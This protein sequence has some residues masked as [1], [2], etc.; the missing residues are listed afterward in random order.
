M[1]LLLN[2]KKKKSQHYLYDIFL[3]YDYFAYFC[4][5]MMI[6]CLSFSNHI[7]PRYDL[8][9]GSVGQGRSKDNKPKPYGSV[10][11]GRSKDNIYIT[12][13]KLKVYGSAYIFPHN[14]TNK[15]NQKPTFQI[16]SSKFHKTTIYLSIYYIISNFRKNK[17]KH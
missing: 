5:T 6:F 17:I 16:V 8:E 13:K 14:P 11:Q 4:T 15:E 3:F 2:K 9:S 1:S 12:R 7:V 10:G